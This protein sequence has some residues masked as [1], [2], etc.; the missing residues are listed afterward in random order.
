LPAERQAALITAIF[1]ATWA[2]AVDV[3]SPDE[4]AGVLEASG[5]DA[6]SLVQQAALS[7]TK[8]RLRQNTD[9]AIQGGIF[10]VPAMVVSSNL[11]W[12][13]DDFADLDVFIRNKDPLP[14]EEVS[15][16]FAVHASASRKGVF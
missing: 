10:G 13:Y 8:V 12:G 11:F 5:F 3:S 7:E 16:W 9:R 2:D 4:L 15:A 14:Q 6:G 1:A